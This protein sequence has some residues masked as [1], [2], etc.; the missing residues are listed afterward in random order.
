RLALVFVI[1]EVVDA[2]ALDRSSERRAVLLVGEW[3][4]AVFGVILRSP[5]RIAEI[6]GEGSRR[7]VGAGLGDGVHHD[8]HRAA[9]CGVEAIGDELELRDGVSAESRLAKTGA[10]PA[11]GHLQIGTAN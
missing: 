6:S 2:I 8:A 5:I 3:D 11:G 7:R 4:D 10:R 9:L 1:V